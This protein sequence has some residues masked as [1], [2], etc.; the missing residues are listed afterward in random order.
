MN[1][2]VQPTLCCGINIILIFGHIDL[3]YVGVNSIKT[4][5]LT[6]LWLRWMGGNIS[7]FSNS[8]KQ[9]ETAVI[10]FFMLA[11]FNGLYLFI[12]HLTCYSMIWPASLAMHIFQFFSPSLLS[13]CFVNRLMEILTLLQLGLFLLHVHSLLRFS[14]IIQWLYTR[15]VKSSASW[16]SDMKIKW[17]N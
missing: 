10:T 5:H 11:S 3:C 17:R 13:S 15:C 7:R 1:T 4:L 2:C 8:L 14:L 6:I 16:G 9:S 12:T